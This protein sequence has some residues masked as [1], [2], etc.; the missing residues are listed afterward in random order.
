[1]RHEHK[2]LQTN[3]TYTRCLCSCDRYKQTCTVVS[4]VCMRTPGCLHGHAPGRYDRSKD[5]IRAEAQTDSMR[6][7]GM[8]PLQERTDA[9]NGD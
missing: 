3:L 7:A 4:L 6:L 8:G 1:M 9:G 5:M 2:C